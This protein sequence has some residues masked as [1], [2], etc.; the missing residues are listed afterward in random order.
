MKKPAVAFPWSDVARERAKHLYL[1]DGYSAGKVAEALTSEFKHSVSR[2]AVIGI[3][4]RMKVKREEAS[5]P[6]VE[7]ERI[8]PKRKPR[9][10]ARPATPMIAE[11]KT[12][13]KTP[14]GGDKKGATRPAHSTLTGMRIGV[15][16][17]KGYVPAEPPA[18]P[19]LN[20]T[21]MQLGKCDCRWP[22]T[23]SAPFLFCGHNALPGSP[24]C[25]DHTSARSQRDQAAAL[26]QMK[27]Y[28]DAFGGGA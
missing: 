10:P 11:L 5:K 3:L 2:S 24:Y 23:A 22:V 25:S 7:F 4:N 19:P 15:S 16:T 18:A 9:P 21:L 6:K 1:V 14:K 26:R 8:M 12:S 17:Q 27:T 28:A 13:R 20:L